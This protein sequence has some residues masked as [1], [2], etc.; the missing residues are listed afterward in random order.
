MAKREIAAGIDLGTTN[1]ALA[2]MDASG[3]YVI[4]S[5]AN[6]E[7]IPSAVY[8]NDRGRLFV[9][10]GAVRSMFEDPINCYR[11]F[12][13]HMGQDDRFEFPGCGKVMTAEQ[14]SAEVLKEL[15]R[16]FYTDRG[17]EL[18]TAVITYPAMFEAPARQ[19]TAR[20]AEQA[21]FA[22]TELIQEPVAA[23]LAYGFS[24]GEKDAVWMV[25][26]LGGGTFDVSLVAVRSGNM[27]V[28]EHAGNNHL[29][30]KNFDLLLFEY[31]VAKLQEKYKLTSFTPHNPEYRGPAAKLLSVVEL[32][33]I[34]LS[35]RREVVVEVDGVLCTDESGKDVVVEVPVARDVYL[36]L[37]MPL[38]E[39]TL[40][41]CNRLL[42]PKSVIIRVDKLVLVGGPTKTPALKEL[43][44]DSLGISLA[45]EE[46]IDPMTV[47]ADGAAI[48]AASRVIPDTSW[49]EVRGPAT[50]EDWKLK[51]SYKGSSNETRVQVGGEL[52]P[53]QGWSGQLS[54]TRVQL[55]RED[56]G[57][58]GEQMP[59][60]S[61]GT[62]MGMVVLRERT[63]NEFKVR[64]FLPG[65]DSIPLADDQFTIL[66]AHVGT[67]EVESR[68]PST[69]SIALV[70]GSVSQVIMKGQSLPAGGH[71]IL[72]AARRF[73]R[74]DEDE[75]LS[76]PIVEGEYERAAGNVHV[77]AL[78]IPCGGLKKDIPKGTAIEVDME[79]DASGQLRTTAYIAIVDEEFENVILLEGSK[80]S[81]EEVAAE[82]EQEMGRLTELRAEVASEPHAEA[83]E[84]LSEIDAGDFPGQI[85]KAVERARQGDPDAREEAHRGVKRL[86]G[87]ADRI[88]HLYRWNRQQARLE[89]LQEKVA[90]RLASGQGEM[91]PS[92]WESLHRV[93]DD[94]ESVGRDLPVLRRRDMDEDYRDV[95]R[96]LEDAASRLASLLGGRMQFRLAVALQALSR[97]PFAVADAEELIDEGI[98]VLERGDPAEMERFYG[99]LSRRVPGLEAM[100]RKELE[101]IRRQAPP[102]DGGGGG[103]GG[104]GGGRDTDSDVEDW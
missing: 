36:G 25:Y 68:L 87:A 20:A 59:L 54:E 95:E 23:A 9:G 85:A 42:K 32:A 6:E 64:A 92:D 12:K 78:R 84:Q 72:R 101:R 2:V 96:R 8:V 24:Q 74:G 82:F 46:V 35:T 88:E 63:L 61:D 40:Q 43:L 50:K 81:V 39:Q 83:E 31:V 52:V 15:R 29:G 100:A 69:L 4:C 56:G 80:I 73:T 34:G 18:T 79:I 70:D 48:F 76:L 57:W 1:S 90:Q 17:E 26:D 38:L 16:N 13:R 41:I 5:Q 67:E 89:E 14:L 55:V 51:L 19:A 33:K 58:S 3:P 53:P 27:E 86:R 49:Q 93:R 21:G 77:G 104:R 47:V 103:R 30:G 65:G 44:A 45:G 37:I 94:L 91:D 99:K 11:E 62:F 22:Y 28:L 60:E 71:K 75:M 66:H 97:N 10:S 7:T 98:E 102:T